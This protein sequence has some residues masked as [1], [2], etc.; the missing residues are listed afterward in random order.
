MNRPTITSDQ[1][2]ADERFQQ[3]CRRPT[4]AERAH[5]DAR[6]A[7]GEL[8]ATAVAEAK[9]FVRQ[10]SF[11]PDEEETTRELERLRSRMTRPAPA[12]KRPRSR[13]LVWSI[14]A[15]LLLLLGAV[16]LWQST[17][18]PE[19]VWTAYETDY[20]E[21]ETIALSDGSTITLN[22]NSRLEVA[23][24]EDRKNRRTRLEGEAYFE[25]K[26]VPERP[27]LVETS[28]AEV[29]V[30]GTSFNVSDR[31]ESFEV[32]LDEGKVQLAFSQ[33]STLELE[34]GQRA[35]LA[36]QKLRVR[37]IATEGTAAWRF[38]RMNFRNVPV[39][40]IVEQVQNDFGWRIRVNDAEIL[41]R[42]V[43]AQIPAN[44]PELLFEA[45]A[46]IYNLKLEKTGEGQ[47]VLR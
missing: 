32:T 41:E 17:G 9:T 35:T 20:A 31:A 14:A 19:P 15:G 13:R 1:L 27:F 24:F 23:E 3:F 18:A 12:R 39:R 40:R 45:L 21:T 8:N 37:E 36:D 47:Y 38:G 7:S 22:A 6:I 29:R 43:N 4:A 42:T 28:R 33:Q 16:A 46:T 25:I 34:P 26:T 5:W 11:L 2:A 30:L 44:D 10:L